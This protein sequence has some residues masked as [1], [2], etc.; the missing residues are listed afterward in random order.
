MCPSN[1]HVR[2]LLLLIALAS[3]S[4]PQ[5]W[6]QEAGVRFSLGDVGDES[7]G[8]TRFAIQELEDPSYWLVQTEPDDEGE[9]VTPEPPPAP[10]RSQLALAAARRR[11]STYRLPSMFGDFHGGSVLQAQVQLP[12]VQ[13]SQLFVDN[14]NGFN[15]FVTNRNGGV[16]GDPNPAVQIDVHNGDASGPVITSSNGNGVPAGQATAYPID[17]PT[18]TGFLAPPNAPGPGTL[19]YNG[20]TAFGPQNDGDGWGLEFSHLFTPDPINV[21]IPSGGGAVR[22]V[23]IAENNSPIPRDRFIFNYNY[24][25]DVISGIGDV[26]RYTFGFEHTITGPS[27]SIQVLFPMA[28]TLDVSQVAGGG[29][30]RDT[31]FGDLTFVFK[32][33]LMERDNFLMSV[34][35][36][37]TVPTG[38]DAS[39]FNTSGQQILD[40][41]HESSHLLP[42]LAMLHTYDSGW[43]WQA[44]VQLDVDTNGNPLRADMTGANLQPVGVLQDQTLMFVDV[45]AG[46][47]LT[48]PSQG[49]PAI[50]ATAEI[51]WVSTLQDADVIN[52]NNLN[53]T[54]ILNRFDVVNLTLG[55]S[56]LVNDSF[57]IR[58]A[59][60]IPLSDDQ[61]DYEAMVQMNFWR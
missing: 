52:T 5:V 14:L 6:G 59:M 60:V 23:K 45:G 29:L 57:T 32:Q 42:F 58:P 28:S 13:I 36:G 20:G 48:D 55:A 35:V 24:F 21:N 61:F 50:A 27:N 8:E 16:G 37:V 47:W 4:S 22:R 25:N 38:D 9:D 54:S 53:I 26:N 11:R 31:E 43:Y 10:S 44:F 40:L 3:F 1:R 12:S 34:G 41:E 33:L 51:H 7:G 30:S 18:A 56:V 46:Y 49:T 17:D 39:V 2:A 19:V 15:I